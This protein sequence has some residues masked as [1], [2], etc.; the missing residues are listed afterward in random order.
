VFLLALLDDGKSAVVLPVVVVVVVVAVV[1]GVV[2]V[3]VVVGVAV[4][5]VVEVDV[6]V[7]V[8]VLKLVLVEPATNKTAFYFTDISNKLT[9]VFAAA[10]QLIFLITNPHHERD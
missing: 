1:L 4:V 7:D 5:D 8:V 6:V 9:P 10:I 3:V 2:V